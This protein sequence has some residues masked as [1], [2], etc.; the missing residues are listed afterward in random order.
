VLTLEAI[1]SGEVHNKDVHACWTLSKEVRRVRLRA[2][3]FV[4]LDDTTSCKES[5][6]EFES[7]IEQ[8]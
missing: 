7:H 1:L 8:K 2:K 4:E 3:R 6:S 5:N